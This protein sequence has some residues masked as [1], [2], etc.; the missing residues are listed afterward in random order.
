MYA[1]LF[2]KKS[3][4]RFNNKE[5]GQGLFSSCSYQPNETI[6]YFHGELITSEEYDQRVIRSQGGYAIKMN[7]RIYLDCKR[8]FD[9]QLCMASYANSPKGLFHFKNNTTR[10]EAN[11]KL[12]I[13]YASRTA[14]LVA[15]NVIPVGQEIL[16]DYDD[17]YIFPNY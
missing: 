13:D 1:Q 3:D 15:T 11:C 16:W 9:L 5:I 12:V 7:E 6:A 17:E 14:R 8:Y 2:S 10:A 4:Y